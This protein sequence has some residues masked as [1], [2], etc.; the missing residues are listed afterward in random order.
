MKHCNPRQLNQ[1]FSIWCLTNILI[2]G[3]SL[4]PKQCTTMIFWSNFSKIFVR[5]KICENQSCEELELCNN[6]CTFIKLWLPRKILKNL[7]IDLSCQYHGYSSWKNGSCEVFFM[8]QNINKKKKGE[9]LLKLP[10]LL[11]L[12]F[13]SKW[14]LL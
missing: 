1:F 13:G 5:N 11:S 3:N 8:I 6:W 10:V 2:P 7:Q 12:Q 14:V 9:S 4:K